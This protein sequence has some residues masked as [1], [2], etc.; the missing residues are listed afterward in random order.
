MLGDDFGGGEE[1]EEDHDE[2]ELGVF[3]DAGDDDEWE[4]EDEEDGHE[5]PHEGA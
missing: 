1:S 3:P 2:D 4:D 5:R